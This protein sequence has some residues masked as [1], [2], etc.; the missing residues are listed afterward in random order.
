MEGKSSC[1]TRR[2]FQQKSKFKDDSDDKFLQA[3]EKIGLLCSFHKDHGV[4]TI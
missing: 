3:L 1:Q 2:K 4:L